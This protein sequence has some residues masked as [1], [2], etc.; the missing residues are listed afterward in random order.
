ME[1]VFFGFGE[2]DKMDSVIKGLMGQC[3]LHNFWARTAHDDS[4][5]PEDRVHNW[6][7]LGIVLRCTSV[8]SHIVVGLGPV[9][10]RPIH[11]IARTSSVFPR[12]LFNNSF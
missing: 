6:S 3:P 7:H 5:P 8:Y 11:S 12:R 2:W 10:T 4:P 9:V 1:F